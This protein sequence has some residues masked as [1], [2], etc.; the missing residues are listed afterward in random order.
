MPTMQSLKSE[1]ARL[2]DALGALSDRLDECEDAAAEAIMLRA[3]EDTRKKI[4]ALDVKIKRH[5]IDQDFL[6]AR[7]IATGE[8]RAITEPRRGAPLRAFK[9][10]PEQAHGF[11]QFLMASIYGSKAAANWCRERGITVKALAE[12]TNT[13]GGFLVPEDWAT[14]IINL[15]ETYGVFAPNCARVPMTGDVV[16]WPRRTTGV[17]AFFVNEGAA[18][19]ESAAGWDEVTLTAKKLMCLTRL[20]TEIAEDA[21]INI[22]DWVAQ[23][24]AYAFAA[25]ED[26]CG[27]NGDGTSTYG[28]IQGLKAAFTTNTA[29]VYT[30]TGHTTADALTNVDLTLLRALLPQYA[31]MGAKWYCSQY[32][33][34]GCFQRLMAQGGGNKIVDL[35]NSCP[36]SYLGDPIVVCQKLPSTSPTG[37]LSIYYGRLDLAAAFGD[38]RRVTIK[39]S[40]DR[41]FDTDQIGLAGTERIDLNVHDVGTGTSNGVNTGPLVALKMG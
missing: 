7:A 13:G 15:K 30:A 9:D 27:F 24:I 23:E 31:K 25:K 19:T 18:P 28:G 39:A 6:A 37:S 21:I 22:A 20:S 34:A 5:G 8:E 3:Y 11:G 33:Y 2:L 1:R 40:A 32:F 4:E 10:Q 16:H 35:T 38:R 12:G 17:T 36:Y 26:D 14:N 29:G 41:Y